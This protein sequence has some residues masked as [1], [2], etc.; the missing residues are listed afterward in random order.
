MKV[1]TDACLFGAWMARSVTGAQ[2]PT[3]SILDIGTGTGLLSLMLAQVSGARIDAVEIDANAAAQAADNFEASPWRERLQVIQGD[4]RNLHLGKRYDL[5]LSNPPFFENSLRSPNNQR[6]LALHSDALS[7][8]E[9]LK[10]VQDHLA[11]GG[12]F[13]ILLPYLQKEKLLESAVSVSLYPEEIM[14]VKQTEKH[15]CFRVMVVFGP[16]KTNPVSRCINIRE[17]DRYSDEFSDLVK[18]YYLN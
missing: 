15:D 6:N 14:T 2:W 11:P 18:D 1:C 9:L 17:G 12:R 10:A 4:I 7:P 13:A 16:D 8:A 3:G 5:I